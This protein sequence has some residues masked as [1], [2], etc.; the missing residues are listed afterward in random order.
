VISHNFWFCS[1]TD[2]KLFSQDLKNLFAPLVVKSVRIMRTSDVPPPPGEIKSKEGNNKPPEDGESKGVGFAR[3][4]Y[5]AIKEITCQ[6]QA[7]LLDSRLENWQKE[8]SKISEVM[9]TCSDHVS[10]SY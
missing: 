6:R 8:R 4:V 9:L 2:H 5:K 10:L 3:S 1:S 7:P